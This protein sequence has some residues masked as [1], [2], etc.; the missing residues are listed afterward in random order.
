MPDML[1]RFSPPLFAMLFDAAI[2][3][4]LRYAVIF[5][6]LMPVAAD[7]LFSFAAAVFS[8]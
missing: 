5:S 4:P 3:T 8:H 6:L 7:E 1:L 2:D